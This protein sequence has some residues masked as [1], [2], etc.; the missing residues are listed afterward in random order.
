VYKFLLLLVLLL[1]LCGPAALAEVQ[2]NRLEINPNVGFLFY[3]GDLNL[4]NQPQFAFRLGYNFTERFGLEAGI[5][6]SKA[7]IDDRHLGQIP[8]L[9]FISPNRNVSTLFYHLDGLLYFRPDKKFNPYV[10]AGVG[11]GHYSPNVTRYVDKFLMDF[12]VGA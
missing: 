11:G 8:E 7:D 1:T 3:D 5:D 2:V 10:V 6:Y 9:R 4:E 12:G